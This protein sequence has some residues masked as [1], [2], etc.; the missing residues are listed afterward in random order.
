MGT[1]T[2]SGAVGR[3]ADLA[4]SP[5]Q[6][7]SLDW[8][9][10]SGATPFVCA[11]AARQGE[12]VDFFMKAANPDD[13]QTAREEALLTGDI[14]IARKFAGPWTTDD[15]ATAL[16]G[17]HPAMVEWVLAQGSGFHP[18]ST[19]LVHAIVSSRD[20][21]FLRRFLAEPGMSRRRSQLG[22]ISL[23]AGWWDGFR[24]C[25]EKLVWTQESGDLELALRL[26]PQGELPD[27]FAAS[28]KAELLARQSI[29][30]EMPD[31][32]FNTAE[33]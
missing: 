21:D 29:L 15:L 14:D 17:W 6:G 32:E 9:D 30:A 1:G 3:R 2:R 20:S 16:S 23:R 5:R 18:C 12:A 27:E 7:F 11:V 10:S 28:L 22:S 19:R 4:I 8:K 24:I 26:A 31:I 25:T 13:L 33:F